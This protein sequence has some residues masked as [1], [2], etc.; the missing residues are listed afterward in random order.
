MSLQRNVVVPYDPDWPRLFERER[1]ALG[2]VLGPWLSG[3][4]HH[5]G[6]TSVPGLAAKP[7]IDMLAG[8]RDLEEARAAFGPLH[9]LGYEY[10]EHRPEAHL[11][12]KGQTHGV[13]LT[14]PGSDLWRERLAFRDALRADPELAREYAE[15]KLAHPADDP[16]AGPYSADKRPFVL[17]VLAEGGIV[18]KPDEERLSPTALRRRL[19]R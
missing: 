3:G 16:A 2:A 7:T 17:R 15:W 14:E 5:I 11:F 9:S 10:R 12:V 8:I 1:E 4:I 13:H 6:S 19:R 18:L